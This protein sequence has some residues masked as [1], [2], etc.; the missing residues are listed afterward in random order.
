MPFTGT[1]DLV[2][3]GDNPTTVNYKFQVIAA[4]P[5]A[6][7]TSANFGKV[8]SG[9][10]TAGQTPATYSYTATAGQAVYF[11]LQNDPNNDLYFTLTDPNDKQI[12]QTYYSYDQGPEVLT[13]S[14]TYTLTVSGFDATTSS[15]AYAFDLSALPSNAKPLS[16]NTPVSSSLATPDATDIYSFTG[17]AGQRLYFDGLSSPGGSTV[18]TLYNPTLNQIFSIGF[19]TNDTAPFTLNQAG[20]YYLLISGQGS[21]AGAYSFQLQD[22]APAPVLKLDGSTTSGS[23]GTSASPANTS[24]NLYQFQGTAGQQL[25]FHALTDTASYSA[26]WTLYGPGNQVVAGR[27]YLLFDLARSRF[28]RT[29]RTPWPSTTKMLRT[30]RPPTRT[31]SWSRRSLKLRPR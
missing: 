8:Q 27:Q 17:G 3:G 6:E 23:F 24:T 25:N 19:S 26:G 21:S 18:A 7:T 13:T 14:G 5:A 28:P 29:A 15:G 30:R 2:L 9:T 1:Y 16:L 4:A 31:V 22:T 10:F 12:F 11:D 20:T